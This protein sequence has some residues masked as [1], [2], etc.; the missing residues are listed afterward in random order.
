MSLKAIAVFD[1]LDET[2]DVRCSDDRAPHYLSCDRREDLVI[3]ERLE[4]FFDAPFVVKA[5][6]FSD[7]RV[8]GDSVAFHALELPR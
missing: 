8:V 2:A 7:V 3:A 1:S 6:I 4:D 5:S